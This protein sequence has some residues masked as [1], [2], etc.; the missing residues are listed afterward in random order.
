MDEELPTINMKKQAMNIKSKTYNAEGR[1]MEQQINSEFFGNA[2]IVKELEEN[3]EDNIVDMLSEED[4]L[5]LVKGKT[6]LGLKLDKEQRQQLKF[7]IKRDEET[8]KILMMIEEYVYGR[9][10]TKYEGFE[11]KN[12]NKKVTGQL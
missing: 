11:T 5:D 12:K 8:D 6:V 4:I 9:R 10:A 7:A 2:N 3:D 1:Y